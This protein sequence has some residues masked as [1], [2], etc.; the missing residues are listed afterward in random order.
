MSILTPPHLLDG[1]RWKGRRVG[2]LG[3]TFN[4]PHE[5]HV[6]ISLAAL[7]ALQLD[8]VWWLVS[9]QNPLK[10]QRPISL[11]ERMKLSRKLIDHPRILVSDLEAQ[12]GTNIT[13][14]SVRGIKTHFPKTDFIWISGMDNALTL[15][16][17]NRW[18]DLLQEISM[19]H[20]TRKPATSLIQSCPLRMSDQK[21]VVIDRGGRL[22][23]APGISYWMMQK[24]M[25]NISSTELR[26]N[27][28]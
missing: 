26:E 23:L 18:R 13:Y 17:W 12:M 25:V 10:T 5:G 11:E 19:V 8:S 2:L 3:G 27:S 24:K 22:S 14:D 28:L 7:H 21:H 4:P 1:P 9:P 16:L 6:R 15:H 20:L